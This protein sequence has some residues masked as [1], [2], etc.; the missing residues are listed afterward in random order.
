LS[1]LD[2]LGGRRFI[3]SMLIGF[4]TAFLTYIGKIDSSTYSLVIL[5]TVGAYITGATVERVKTNATV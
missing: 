4:T 3:M 5:G 1:T 2:K